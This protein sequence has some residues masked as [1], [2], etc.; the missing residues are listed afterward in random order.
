MN[1]NIDRADVHFNNA[2]DVLIGHIGEG[3]IA[4]EEEA[5]AAVVIFK[6]ERFAHSFGQLI[7]KAKDAFIGAVVLAIHEVIGEFQPQFVVFFFLNMVKV[8]FAFPLHLDGEGGINHVK[9]VIQYIADEIAIDR[10]QAIAGL[11]TGPGGRG[12][13]GDLIDKNGH[14]GSPD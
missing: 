6:I 1:R 13:G 4:A 14:R 11:D 10:D 3:D 12:M 8:R 2:G 7:D 9:A 5:H